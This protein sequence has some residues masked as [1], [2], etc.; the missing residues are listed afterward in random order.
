MLTGGRNYDRFVFN[1]AL[2]D[3]I[4]RIADF[5]HGADT[6]WLENSVFT[7]LTTT[8]QLSSSAF[9]SGAAAHDATDR[10][11]YNSATGAL[12]YDT[13]G[14]GAAAPVQFALVATGLNVTA[15]DFY[16]C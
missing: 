11:I 16:V 2:K 6:I 12:T 15:T 14:T 13:D 7:A 9:Y 5:W 3:G 1:T 8:G 4:D 10:I